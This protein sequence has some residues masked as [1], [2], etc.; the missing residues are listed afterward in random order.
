MSPR[1]LASA[2]ALIPEDDEGVET[3]M[4]EHCKADCPLPGGTIDWDC[5]CFITARNRSVTVNFD[6][7]RPLNGGISLAAAREKEEE[8]E[9]KGEHGD[10]TPLSLN[11]PDPSSPSLAG[12]ADEEK[13]S[14]QTRR[15]PCSSPCLR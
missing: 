5:F 1:H 3:A 9:E 8:G 13:T 15:R 2:L 7:R 10:S 12:R 4:T 11:D 6:H 14:P